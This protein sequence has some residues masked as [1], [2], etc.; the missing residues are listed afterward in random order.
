MR[1]RGDVFVLGIGAEGHTAHNLRKRPDL[2]LNFPAPEMWHAVESLALLTGANP[3]PDGKP[4][5]CRYE[6]D[7]FGA[8]GLHPVAS[9]LILH[10]L[11]LARDDVMRTTVE[12]VH[13]DVVL[14]AIALA[15]ELTLR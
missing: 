1:H 4:A 9:E 8:A 13:R 3:V 5:N 11:D 6:K 7:K 14:D 2:V 15:V 10:D 12:V